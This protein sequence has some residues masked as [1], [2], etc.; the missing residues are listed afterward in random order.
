MQQRAAERGRATHLLFVQGA[1]NRQ[2]E[3]FNRQAEFCESRSPFYAQLCRRLAGDPRVGELAPDFRWDLPLRL[4]GGL[5]YLVLSGRADWDHID[6]ALDDQRELLSEFVRKQSVQTNEVRR[7]WG[8]LPAFLSLAAPRVDLVE[9]GA[10]AGL[11]LAVDRYDYRYRAGSWGD[12]TDVLVLDGDDRGGPPA[13]LL[14]RSLDVGRRIGLDL[15]PVGLEE[16]GARLLEA[17]V[18]PDQ[19]ERIERL[20]HAIDVARTCDIDLR[21]G[22]YV[23]LLPAVLAERR[24]DALMV[25][26]HSV[27][28]TYLDDDRYAQLVSTLTRAGADGPLAWVSFEGPR[29]D[30]DYGAVALDVTRWPGG[31]TR[32]LAKVDFH[33][34]WLEWG[35]R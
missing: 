26:F 10:S 33:A 23:D 27:S 20:R 2:A 31:E 28:T 35:G 22:D 17:F 12:G 15:D 30:P 5:H 32:Q 3:I 9:L 24:D 29:H 1:L 8:V 11:L 18:W 25:V 14:G 21:R 4:L 34:A 7:A 19:H 13:D 6:A 16:Q